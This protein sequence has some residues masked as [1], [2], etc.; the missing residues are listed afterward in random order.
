MKV[1]KL[2]PLLIIMLLLATV[3][4]GCIAVE[5]KVNANGSCDMTYTIDTSAFEGMMTVDDVEQTIKD[6]VDEIN[7]NAG[8]DIAKLKG[9][10]EDKK[11]S[12]LT[13]TISISDLNKM[14]G[15]FYGTVKEYREKDGTGLDNLVKAKGTSNVDE[16]DISDNLQMVFIPGSDDSGSSDFGLIEITVVVP[17]TIQYVTDGADVKENNKAVFTAQTPL[18]VFNKGGGFPLV[19]ALLIALVLI[20]GAVFAASRKKP[21]VDQAPAIYHT[22]PAENPLTNTMVDPLAVAPAEDG[23]NELVEAANEE[24]TTDEVPA[25]EIPTENESE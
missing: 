10:K 1:K 14:E 6:S 8:K 25:Q 12:T 15:A 11:K 4:S 7:T 24:V 5:M 19:P 20:I 18:V 17:G 23:A 3:L 22:P 9:I 2:V 16:E 13:A 21:V